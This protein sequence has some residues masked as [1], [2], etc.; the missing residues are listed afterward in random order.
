MVTG[1]N[2]REFGDQIDKTLRGFGFNN[3]TEGFWCRY[4]NWMKDKWCLNCSERY[5]CS[6]NFPRNI[7]RNQI[8]EHGLGNAPKFD[9]VLMW[10]YFNWTPS[11][12]LNSHLMA[13]IATKEEPDE[14]SY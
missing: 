12:L 5:T 7:L 14:D 8:K 6:G 4:Y 13:Q 10:N 1:E 3:N 2:Y 11:P 9:W